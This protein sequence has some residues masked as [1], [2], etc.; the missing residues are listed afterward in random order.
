[1]RKRDE[2]KASRRAAQKIVW[3]VRQHR[4]NE[5]TLDS[6]NMKGKL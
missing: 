1:M 2:G 4:P 6:T 5:N 3:A